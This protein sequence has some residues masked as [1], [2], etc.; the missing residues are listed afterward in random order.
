[1]TDTQYLIYWEEFAD[2]TIGTLLLFI[3]VPGSRQSRVKAPAGWIYR[4][5]EAVTSAG[6]VS[7]TL[8]GRC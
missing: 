7:S 4:Q 1:M 2:D 8:T 3:G 6:T 5:D